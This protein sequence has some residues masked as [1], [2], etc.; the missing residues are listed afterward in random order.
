M[1][2]SVTLPD[3]LK[4][5]LN[6]GPGGFVDIGPAGVTIQ[7]TNLASQG[8]DWSNAIVNGKLP[9]TLNGTS[10]SMGGKPAYVYY[11]LPSQLNVLAPDLAPGPATVTVTTAATRALLGA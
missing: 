4:Y 2:F 1:G 9:T 5:P 7:G 10:V 6:I 11:T 3:A 8:G